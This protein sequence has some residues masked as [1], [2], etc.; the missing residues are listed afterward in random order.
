MLRTDGAEL[1]E[2]MISDMLGTGW[3]HTKMYEKAGRDTSLYLSDQD[4]THNNAINDWSAGTYGVVNWC[5][6]WQLGW[7]LSEVVVR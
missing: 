7:R 3:S 2:D 1:M 5:G 4:L 6:T